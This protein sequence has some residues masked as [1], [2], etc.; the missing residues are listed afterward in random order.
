[1]RNDPNFYGPQ[2]LKYT[3]AVDFWGTRNF[4]SQVAVGSLPDSTYNETHWK[5][6]TFIKLYKQALA[7]VDRKKR[8]QII[9][10]MQRIEYDRGGHIIP[11]FKN[12][13]AAY[14]N[15]VGGFKRDVG[16]LALN[17]YGNNFRTIYFV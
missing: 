6:P 8:C 3:F 7:T 5:D 9:K 2:Y 14:N 17:K 16:T 13:L 10:D 1:M 4:L 11:W 15:K 12:Q